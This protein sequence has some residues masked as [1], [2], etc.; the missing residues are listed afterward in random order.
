[1]TNV[2]DERRKRAE[3][4]ER[5]KPHKSEASWCQY[6]DE[7][8]G[9]GCMR[10]V[11]DRYICTVCKPRPQQSNCRPGMECW[12]GCPNCRSSV[13]TPNE[14]RQQLAWVDPW[15]EQRADGKP[16]KA[17]VRYDWPQEEILAFKQAMPVEGRRWGD[18]DSITVYKAEVGGRVLYGEY[19][20]GQFVREWVA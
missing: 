9:P 10:W 14:Q 12:Q 16:S 7:V 4:V 19:R 17:Q 15:T 18:G 11:D 1:M 13:L 3:A 6:C 20:N 8:R 2:Y 5:G